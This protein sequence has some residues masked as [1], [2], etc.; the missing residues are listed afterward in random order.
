VERGLD[1]IGR[2]EFR[3]RE[4][5]REQRV[6]GE[7][8][9]LAREPAG[10]LVDRF[11]G[12]RIEERAVGAGE[13]EAMG[14]IAGELLAGERGGDCSSVTACAWPPASSGSNAVWQRL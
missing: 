12:G 3:A 2:G 4:R 6:V 9:D 5:C 7:Q 13:A 10:R 8:V 1:M 14:E 11:F